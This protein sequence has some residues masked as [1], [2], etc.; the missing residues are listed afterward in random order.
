MKKRLFFSAW[1]LIFFLSGPAWSYAAQSTIVETAG[2]ACMGDDKSRKQTEA[3]AMAHAKRAA[4]ENA[5]TY[6]REKNLWGII[7]ST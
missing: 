6:I 1:L 3:E 7:A 5:S 2:E 4:V